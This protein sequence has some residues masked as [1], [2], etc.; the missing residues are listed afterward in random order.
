VQLR[1]DPTTSARIVYTLRSGAL[2][3]PTGARNG[4]WMEV[5]DENGNRGWMSSAYANPR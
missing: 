3:Y 2:V 5:D 1:K 4:I